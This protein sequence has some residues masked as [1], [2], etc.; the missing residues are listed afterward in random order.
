MIRTVFIFATMF[1]VLLSLSGCTDRISVPEDLDQ[2]VR[3]MPQAQFSSPHGTGPVE[4][5]WLESFHDAQLETL[6]SEAMAHNP[7]LKVAA[8]NVE[9]AKAN[10]KLASSSI[11][12]SINYGGIVSQTST[13]RNLSF[14]GVGATWEPDLWGRLSAQVQSAEATQKAIEADY[15]GAR[16]AL[17]ADVSR[18]WFALIEAT[19]LKSLSK[20]ILDS[21]KETLESAEVKYRIGQILRKDVA[22]AQADYDSAEDAYIQSENAMKIAARVVEVLLGR[23]PSAEMIAVA[24]FPALPPFPS[25]GIPADLLERRPDLI[26]KEEMLRAA[27]FASKDAQLAQLPTFRITLRGIAGSLADFLSQLGA[28]VTGPLYQGGAIEAQIESADAEQKMALA[29][30]QGAVL[31]AFKDVENALNNEAFLLKR[32]TTIEHA[33]KGYT[34]ALKDTRVQ[35]NIGKVDLVDVQ[36]QQAK[37]AGA[38]ITLLHLRTLLLQNRVNMYLALGGGFDENAAMDTNMTK[39][40]S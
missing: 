15:A 36:I 23:Y 28:G 19:R 20:E 22:Q 34:I 10:S 2:T 26:S 24:G 25:S 33:V 3:G 8:Y 17:A 37:L 11:K 4:N 6:V 16:Q 27:F 1:S 21:Y 31:N 14:G 38:Q 13:G 39:G 12:P 29:D 9:Q 32:I 30:Y 35:Y 7:T 40:V 5:G 18:A